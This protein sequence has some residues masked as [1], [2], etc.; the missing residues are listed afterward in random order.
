MTLSHP[1]SRPSLQ[2]VRQTI[3]NRLD[4]ADIEGMRQLIIAMYREV[5]GDL[6]ELVSRSLF[7]FRFF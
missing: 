4:V 6:D 2:K 7:L 3:R 1:Q 5:M